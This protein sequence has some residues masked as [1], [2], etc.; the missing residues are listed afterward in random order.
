MKK[1]QL[2]LPVLAFLLALSASL[3]TAWAYFTTYAEAKGGQVIHL[4][5]GTEIHEEFSSWTKRIRISSEE[6]SQPVYVRVKAF[7]GSQYKLEYYGED[8][9][10]AA[11]GF[12]IYDGILSGGGVT[13]E[14]E[15][16]IG[17]IPVNDDLKDGLTLHVPVV[18][19]TTL[20][21]YG[22]DGSPLPP[23]WSSVL[24]S[25]GQEEG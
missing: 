12:W 17:G 16:H 9:T 4:G 19:E 5:G 20:V 25:G 13:S 1:R 3:G 23:D 14:L 6:G 7:A 21:L 10:A 2:L 8:W 22:P 18:Y 11:D 15:I 24:D